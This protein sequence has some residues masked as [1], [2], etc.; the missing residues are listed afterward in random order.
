M[1]DSCGFCRRRGEACVKHGGTKSQYIPKKP[2]PVTK[3]EWTDADK[4]LSSS[5]YPSPL[6]TDGTT[7]NPPPK[8]MKSKVTTSEQVTENTRIVQ[9][10]VGDVLITIKEPI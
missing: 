5:G 4:S 8:P 10:K 2:A 1:D 9:I 6:P 3:A 7:A